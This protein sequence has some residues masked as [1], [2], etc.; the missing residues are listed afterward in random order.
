M[1]PLINDIVVGKTEQV[2]RNFLQ[3]DYTVYH[4]SFPPT[5]HVVKRK[6]SDFRKVRNILQKLYPFLRLPYLEPEGWINSSEGRDPDTLQKYKW[7][8]E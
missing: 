3:S 4:I 2:S 1:L 7:M 8:I 6:F 5:K